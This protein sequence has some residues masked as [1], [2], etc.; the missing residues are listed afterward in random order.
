MAQMRFNGLCWLP[1]SRLRVVVQSRFM[2]YRSIA[3]KAVLTSKRQMQ[4]SYDLNIFLA[5]LSALRFDPL[6]THRAAILSFLSLK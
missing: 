2:D 3:A 6:S 4:P 1:P 5:F